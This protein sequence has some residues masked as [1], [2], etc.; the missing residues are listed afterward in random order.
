MYSTHTYLTQIVF[1]TKTYIFRI[2]FAS[3]FKTIF[4]RLT[5]IAFLI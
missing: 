1:K 3:T 5:K 4:E 2:F